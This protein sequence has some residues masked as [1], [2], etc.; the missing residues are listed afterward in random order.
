MNRLVV[1][2]QS[3]NNIPNPSNYISY[4]SNI[5]NQP[6]YIPNTYRPITIVRPLTVVVRSNAYVRLTFSFTIFTGR[7]GRTTD[8]GED[9]SMVPDRDCVGR[10]LVCTT[11]S[12]GHLSQGGVDGRLDIL[13]NQF[14]ATIITEKT[15]QI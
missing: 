10:L 5:Y 9:W 2:Y 1:V 15:I 4:I 14:V 6:L 11:R 8:A 12:A 7:F 3:N 13:H